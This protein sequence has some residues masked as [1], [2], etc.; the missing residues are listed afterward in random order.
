MSEHIE[1]LE[2]IDI[3]YRELAEEAGITHWERVPA[4]GVEEDFIEDLASAVVEALPRMEQRPLQEIDEGRPVSLRV[5]ND[6]VSLRS[7]E[8]IGAE[9]GPVRVRNYRLTPSLA[10]NE[11]HQ[12]GLGFRPRPSTTTQ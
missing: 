12:R 9:Y 7:K 3:E 10:Q 6:L 11:R 2:E 8:E 1:T 4:L 5:V